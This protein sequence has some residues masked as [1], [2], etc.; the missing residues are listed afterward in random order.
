MVIL[1]YLIIVLYYV[2]IL[3]IRNIKY[4]VYEQIGTCS[5][6][7]LLKF[8]A[9]KE[10]HNADYITHGMLPFGH[11]ALWSWSC[12]IWEWYHFGPITDLQLQRRRFQHKYI[13]A[14]CKSDIRCQCSFVFWSCVTNISIECLKLA[15]LTVWESYIASSITRHRGE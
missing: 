1:H 4:F 2:L 15:T 7:Y 14:W 12:H 9:S 5:A 3:Y 6:E 8:R 10:C 13:S 11:I